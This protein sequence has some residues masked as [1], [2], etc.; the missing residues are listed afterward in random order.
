MCAGT[1]EQVHLIIFTC[2]H[3]AREEIKTG[4]KKERELQEKKDG[5]KNGKKKTTGKQRF[6]ERF[7]ENLP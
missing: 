2:A 6:K 5:G 1:G 4:E 3:N 7:R